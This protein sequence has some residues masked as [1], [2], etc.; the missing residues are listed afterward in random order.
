VL[1]IGYNDLRTGRADAHPIQQ[2]AVCEEV[3]DFR[4]LSVSLTDNPAREPSVSP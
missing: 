4:R 1:V 2:C 3:Y